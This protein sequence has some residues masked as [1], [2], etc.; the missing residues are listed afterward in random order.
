[1]FAHL[2]NGAD[3]VL[4]LAG[5]RAAVGAADMR[6]EPVTK[7][8]THSCRTQRG[9]LSFQVNNVE[10]SRQAL[11]KQTIDRTT[12]KIETKG[13]LFDRTEA[14]PCRR[15]ARFILLAVLPRY[16]AWACRHGD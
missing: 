10:L 12:G 15:A 2:G 7:L 16:A 9:V 4:W 1:M 13:L 3:G 8:V 6:R 11:D 14:V 5:A